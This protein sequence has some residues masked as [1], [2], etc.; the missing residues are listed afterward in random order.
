MLIKSLNKQTT[1]TTKKTLTLSFIV[2]IELYKNNSWEREKEVGGEKKR[3]K[4]TVIVVFFKVKLD[5]S[6]NKQ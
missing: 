2:K 1:T 3:R 4:E 6:T 5:S